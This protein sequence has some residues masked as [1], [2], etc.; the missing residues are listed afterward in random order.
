[1]Y[2]IFLDSKAFSIINIMLKKYTFIY[3]IKHIH[4]VF[5]Y[6]LYF[7]IQKH[8]IYYYTE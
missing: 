8:L 1:M 7:Y 4:F 6:V 5:I 3:K 2:R